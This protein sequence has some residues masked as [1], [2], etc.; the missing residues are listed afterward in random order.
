MCETF[1]LIG[2][3]TEVLLKVPVY[4]VIYVSWFHSV[5]SS[6]RFLCITSYMCLGSTE[7][8]LKVPVYYV[9]YVSWFD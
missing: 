4:Y 3:V 5:R 9:I 1:G 7:V 8:L 6:S 2:S